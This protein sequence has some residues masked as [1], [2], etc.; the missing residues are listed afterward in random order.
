MYKEAHGKS[1][2]MIMSLQEENEQ[3]RLSVCDHSDVHSCMGLTCVC[4]L[5]VDVVFKRVR[6]HQSSRGDLICV[7]SMKPQ[8]RQFYIS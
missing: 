3:L 2:A 1:L 5:F 8:Y 6:R 4:V 7:I